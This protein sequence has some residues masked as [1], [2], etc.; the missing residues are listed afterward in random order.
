[1]FGMIVYL[2]ILQNSNLG[3]IAQADSKISTTTSQLPLAT[4]TPTF[5]ECEIEID[6]NDPTLMHD[7]LMKTLKIVGTEMSASSPDRLPLKRATI[8]FKSKSRK[9]E[10][11]GRF[12]ITVPD[13]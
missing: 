8:N 3:L 6:I 4:K 12:I 13:P 2:C 5:R 7:A 9:M 11:S 1:M 10:I